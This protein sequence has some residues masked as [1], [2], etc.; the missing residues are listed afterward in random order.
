[1]VGVTSFNSLILGGNCMRNE[2]TLYV[3]GTIA[4][5]PQKQLMLILHPSVCIRT[6]MWIEVS[7]LSADKL[8]QL[9]ETV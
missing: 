3:W 7:K 1:M 2:A 9:L 6:Y 4:E 8:V 5:S